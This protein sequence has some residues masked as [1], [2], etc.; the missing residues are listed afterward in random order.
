VADECGRARN[1]DLAAA[2]AIKIS[3]LTQ[4]LRG[5]HG[6]LVPMR[7]HHVT[8]IAAKKVLL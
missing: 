2:R 7:R 5:T 8:I 6:C 3:D 4:A 1:D